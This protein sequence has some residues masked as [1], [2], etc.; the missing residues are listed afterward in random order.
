VV[1]S[2][3][4]V[5]GVVVAFNILRRSMIN[6]NRLLDI[7]GGSVQDASVF[8][9][10]VVVVGV[11]GVVVSVVVVSGVVVA[12]NIM[13]LFRISSN[14]LLGTSWGLVQGASVSEAVVV[15]VVVAGVVVLGVVVSGAVVSGVVVAFNIMRLFRISSN[16]L[17]GIPG[18][19]VQGA[20]VVGVAGVVVSGVVVSV[21][22]VSGV[23]VSGVVIAFNI[24]RL[25]RISSNRLLGTPGGLVQGASVSE[26]VIAV[27]A[28]MVAAFDILRADDL[29]SVK[30]PS[31]SA[32]YWT[33]VGWTT[34]AVV[35]VVASVGV[36]ESMRRC[37][38]RYSTSSFN[39]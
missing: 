16:R 29:M 35:A 6:P 21:V 34:N 20:S 38:F 32:A 19:L 25:F 7:L 11:S 3:V 8:A 2:C 14:R 23:V 1:V 18:G 22:V 10:V 39:A 26:A 9:A 33:R 13:R 4:V 17:L 27:V 30:S 24:M 5:S 12:F 36:C 15:V 31:V 37:C 28:G